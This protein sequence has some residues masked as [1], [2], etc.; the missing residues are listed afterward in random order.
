MAALV[1]EGQGLHAIALILLL[2]GC[3]LLSRLPVFDTGALWGI[4]TRGWFWIA[5]GIAVTHQV[6]VWVCWRAQLH[7][8][9]LTRL[10]GPAAFPSYAVGFSILGIARVVAVFLLAAAGAGTATGVDPVVLRALALVALAGALYLFYSVKRYFTFKRAFG[11]DHFDPSYRTMPMVKGG[12]FRFTANG[13]YVYGFLLI[14]VPGLWSGAVAAL[15]AALFNHLYIWVHYFATERPD[16][17]RIYGTPPPQMPSGG[18]G[19]PAGP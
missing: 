15:V 14:W 10:L 12:I 8:Q 2:A 19:G 4:A 16:M 3:F 13:M 9:L 5:V 17:R 6:Y 18:A 11:I 1:F 7:A